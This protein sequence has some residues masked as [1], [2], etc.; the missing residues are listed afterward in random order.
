[1][2][3][4]LFLKTVVSEPQRKLVQKKIVND[5]TLMSGSYQ[6]EIAAG[7]G[8]KEQGDDAPGS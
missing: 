4:P 3:A 1:M 5:N 2:R 7:G 6:I 8:R